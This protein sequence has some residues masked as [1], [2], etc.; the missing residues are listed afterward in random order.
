MD[1]NTQKRFVRCWQSE[2][3]ATMKILALLKKI[4]EAEFTEQPTGRLKNSLNH[5]YQKQDQACQTVIQL[6]EQGISGE[7]APSQCGE[8]LG[9]L[10]GYV[11]DCYYPL[12]EDY[13]PES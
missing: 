2:H 11:E 5:W 7:D 6:I 3:Q 9:K 1:L 4:E 13:R 8:L 12:W 10:R